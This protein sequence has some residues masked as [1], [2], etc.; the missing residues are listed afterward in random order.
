MHFFCARKGGGG[1]VLEDGGWWLGKSI[2]SNVKMVNLTFHFYRKTK[3][4]K[5]NNVFVCKNVPFCRLRPW[6]KL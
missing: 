1:G 3:V 2:L 5:F 6:S 4:L